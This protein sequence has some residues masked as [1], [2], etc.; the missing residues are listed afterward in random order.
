MLNNSVVIEEVKG[1]PFVSVFDS[2]PSGFFL[3]VFCVV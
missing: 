3:C 2:D 1:K